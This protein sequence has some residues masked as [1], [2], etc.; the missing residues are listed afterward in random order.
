MGITSKN[1]LEFFRKVLGFR[2]VVQRYTSVDIR[3]V[4]SILKRREYR[5]VLEFAELVFRRMVE[6]GFDP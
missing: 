3:I 1:D 4:D 6:K 2:N 5:K